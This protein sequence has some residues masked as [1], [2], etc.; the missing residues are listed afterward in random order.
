MDNEYEYKRALIFLERKVVVHV[1][2]LKGYWCNGILL[3]VSQEH[4]IV[5]DRY[6]GSEKLIFFNELKKSLEQFKEVGE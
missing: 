5:K 6:D 1:S 4:F 3:E 2:T